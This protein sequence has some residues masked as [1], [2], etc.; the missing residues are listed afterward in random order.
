MTRTVTGVCDSVEK[1]RNAVDELIYDGI[2]R[3]KVYLDEE[4]NQVKVMIPDT[5]EVE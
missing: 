4:T 1:A 2:D 5:I 3:E